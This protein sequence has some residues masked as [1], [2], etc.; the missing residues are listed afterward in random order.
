MAPDLDS[1]AAVRQYAEDEL[2]RSIRATHPE[3]EVKFMDEI[4]SGDM[5]EFDLPGIWWRITPPRGEWPKWYT[6]QA[7]VDEGEFLI[8]YGYSTHGP[9]D[10]KEIMR[11][12]VHVRFRDLLFASQEF[13]EVYRERFTLGAVLEWMLHAHEDYP[14]NVLALT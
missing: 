6:L 10:T 4:R 5:S 7:R 14:M 1:E 2:R 12:A 13:P 9:S 3:L 11:S 8:W